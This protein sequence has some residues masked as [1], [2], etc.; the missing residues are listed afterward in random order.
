MADPRPTMI[1]VPPRN[2]LTEE[3]FQIGLALCK[4]EKTITD[5]TGY[6]NKDKW[7]KI[8]DIFRIDKTHHSIFSDLDLIDVLRRDQG[9]LC[10][11]AA[12]MCDLRCQ[13]LLKMLE[14]HPQGVV[15]WHRWYVLNRQWQI[16][17]RE[18]ARM[19]YLSEALKQHARLH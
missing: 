13:W 4:D 11:A 3:Q 17:L 16:P 14:Q 12:Y 8:T 2:L 15:H 1:M 6:T 18:R 5:G 10:E 9:L 7:D 19:H